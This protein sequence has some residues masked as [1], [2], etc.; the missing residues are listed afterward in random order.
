MDRTI[1]SR[2]ACVLAALWLNA[3]GGLP[4]AP[5]RPGDDP[6][7]RPPDRVVMEGL[8]P[9][10]DSPDAMRLLPGDIIDVRTISDDA[11]SSRCGPLGLRIADTRHRQLRVNTVYIYRP[12]MGLRPMRPS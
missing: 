4:A 5:T 3:C 9:E 10:A 11:G 8:S 1:R 2:S 6:A 7:F 12:L